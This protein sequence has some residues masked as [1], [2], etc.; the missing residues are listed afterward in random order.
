MPDVNFV[1]VLDHGADPT[2]VADSTTAFNDAIDE[3]R[4]TRV[5]GAEPYFKAALI[6]PRGV[7][8]VSTVNFTG[9]LSRNFDILGFGAVIVGNT[10]GKAIFD[11]VNSRWIRVHGLT[12][13]GESTAIPRCG[14]QLGP[15]GT[16]TSGNCLFYDVSV[17]GQYTHAPLMNTGCETTQYYS[18]RFSNTNVNGSYSAIFD[19]L[20]TYLPQS[21]YA[22]ITRTTGTAVSFTNNAS[23]SCQY[24]HEG[25]GPSVYIA[26]S[27]THSFDRGCYFLSF[28]DAA[29]NI[30]G[31]SSRRNSN[32]SI[33]GLF[34]NAQVDT[35]TVGNTGIKYVC[36]FIG[37][38]SNT[39][40]DGFYLQT[41]SPH[42]AESIFY[43]DNS[44]GTLRLSDVTIDV[45]NLLNANA[46][47]FEGSGIT[48]H[49]DIR[50]RNASKLN[51]GTLTNFTGRVMVDTM[52]SVPSFPP[53]GAWEIVGTSDG[54]M[55]SH[56]TVNATSDAPI[57]GYIN[58]KDA[59]GVT[60]KIAIIS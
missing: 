52:S 11:C 33:Q 39:A 5:A 30:H 36:R 20:S 48:I 60:R 25:G 50:T 47:F 1:S 42:A 29:L 41:F 14:I 15:K 44:G 40:I 22:T 23:Y 38:G 19:G 24:R 10:A 43:N 59:G 45:Q 34:E 9:L 51:L 26:G 16:E 35:P 6:I 27:N 21:D 57:T 17:L 28:N 2:G 49:G 37:D 18:C 53:A 46:T 31:T 32:L 8:S 4:D 3:I 58:I 12:I 13:L 55:R 54:Q 7:Y 56:C